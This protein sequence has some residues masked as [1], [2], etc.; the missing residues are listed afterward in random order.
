MISNIEMA[1]LAFA[2]VGIALNI[3]FG[4][5]TD[6]WRAMH[7]R[8]TTW[9]RMAGFALL[10]VGLYMFALSLIPFDGAMAMISR[11]S[12]VLGVVL[13]TGG[14]IGLFVP[15]TRA[16][17]AMPYADL[18]RAMTEAL[19]DP[20]YSAETKL[21]IS[22]KRDLLPFKEEW[23]SLGH[24]PSLAEYRSPAAIAFFNK[25]L[26][27]TGKDWKITPENIDAVFGNVM[28]DTRINGPMTG[29]KIGGGG[30]NTFDQTDINAIQTGVDL[31]NTQNNKFSNTR[32]SGPKGPP[33]K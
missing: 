20:R 24:R 11:I 27:E 33:A 23:R 6:E 14:I 3:I 9:G 12:I 28:L 21:V 4:L 30:G 19:A 16:Q 5:V 2:V 1:G 32:I 18:E 8:A 25:R 22:H 29:I 26:S 15:I 7:K 17:T 13:L 31:E 10:G